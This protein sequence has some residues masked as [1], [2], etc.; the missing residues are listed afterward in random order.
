[1]RRADVV[2]GC[3]LVIRPMQSH[4]DLASSAEA[5]HP[6]TYLDFVM[7]SKL[8]TLRTLCPAHHPQL[9]LA[10]N[11]C[12]DA[13]KLRT[14]ELGRSPS[15]EQNRSLGVNWEPISRWK[16]KVWSKRCETPCKQ[17]LLTLYPVHSIG[18]VQMAL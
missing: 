13:A 4:G 10:T 3:N 16:A 14:R 11:S 5:V 1:M 7:R 2:R 6:A 12:D 15:K 9:L 8:C 17:V 18:K